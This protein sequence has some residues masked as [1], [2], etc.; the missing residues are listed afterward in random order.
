[1]VKIYLKGNINYVLSEKY[2]ILYANTMERRLIMN[3]EIG[4]YVPFMERK[5]ERQLYYLNTK[6]LN[7][8][9]NLEEKSFEIDIDTVDCLRIADIIYFCEE[10]NFNFFCESE[11]KI[12]LSKK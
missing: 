5:R 2:N 11:E 3:K 7:N 9:I 8:A 1:M 12:I 6:F 10:H 4:F